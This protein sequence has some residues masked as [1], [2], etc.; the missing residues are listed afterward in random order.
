[1]VRTCSKIL[2]FFVIMG[3]IAGCISGIGSINDV[4]TV[5][6][7]DS[8][9]TVATRNSDSSIILNVAVAA[10][11]SPKET[12]V[13]YEELFDHISEIT[14]FEIVFKQRKTYDEVNEMLFNNEVD[15]A[16]ICSGAY[17][18]GKEK[19]KMEILVMPESNGKAYY[20]AYLIAHVNSDI[21]KFE[22]LQNKIFAF[23]DPISHSGKLYVDKRLKEIGK[24]ERFFSKTIF[25]NAHDVSMQLV[26]KQIVDGASIKSNV[27]E[28]QK[29][30]HPDRVKN[31]RII[32]HSEPYGMPPIVV[33]E[34]LDE[35]R[36]KQ[37]KDMFLTLHE[38]PEGKR[39]LDQLMIDRFVLGHDGDYQSIRDILV[40]FDR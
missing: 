39:I 14:G 19:N 36:K 6:F 8:S 23:T 22:D 10:M 2:L 13:F 31:I 11:I 9:N 15:L 32:E 28:Y 21:Y 1:M 30:F 24:D 35:D 5:D 38:N 4:L 18:T 33:P 25:S 26:S 3:F 37:I 34:N 12:L 20:Q 17:A 40:M 29:K 27:Y 16:F 7:T